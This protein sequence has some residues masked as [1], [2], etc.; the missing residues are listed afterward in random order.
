MTVKLL[1]HSLVHQLPC[2]LKD[3]GEPLEKVIPVKS[4]ERYVNTKLCSL[5]ISLN[6]ALHLCE[7][8]GL[9][10]WKRL[11]IILFFVDRCILIGWLGKD[12]KAIWWWSVRLKRIFVQSKWS[13]RLLPQHDDTRTQPGCRAE[14][15]SYNKRATIWAHH[16]DSRRYGR[17]CG[18]QD[19]GV[20]NTE[21][22]MKRNICFCGRSVLAQTCSRKVC[23]LAAIK[24]LL[25]LWVE[26]NT[27]P[28]L[29]RERKKNGANFC[30]R[31]L[32]RSRKPKSSQNAPSSPQYL[33][34]HLSKRL[35]QI[36]LSLALLGAI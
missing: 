27:T 18:L 29:L 12:W 26:G 16:L 9:W 34:S 13:H 7:K 14:E 10:V 8:K 1:H 3:P 24:P 15:A 11:L 25:L 23:M 35:C 22:C 31:L 32:W 17:T 6:Y 5:W 36:L 19:E 20:N 30:T 28:Q 21:V 4:C 2:C 33:G